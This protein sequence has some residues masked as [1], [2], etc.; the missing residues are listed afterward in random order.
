[1]VVEARYVGGWVIWLRFRDDTAEEIDLEPER[2]GRMFEPLRDGVPHADMALR[3][4][5]CASVPTRQR[6]GNGMTGEP[7]SGPEAFA[8]ARREEELHRPDRK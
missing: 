1:V 4:R 8:S 3:R 2:Y 7:L 5:L 6:P